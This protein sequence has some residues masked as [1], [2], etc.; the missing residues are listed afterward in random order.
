MASLDEFRSQLEVT[1]KGWTEQ[2][3]AEGMEKG[4]ERGMERG[5][6]QGRAEGIAAQRAVLRRQVALRFGTAARHLAPLLD[7][8]HSTAKLAE[9]GE[10]LVVDTID[11]LTAKIEAAVADDRFH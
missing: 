6:E 11:Q 9:I 7:E 10:W 8:V 1:A 2:W 3:F 4:I 5:I